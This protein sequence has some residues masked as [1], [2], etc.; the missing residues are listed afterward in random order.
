MAGMHKIIKIFKETKLDGKTVKYDEDPIDIIRQAEEDKCLYRFR[1]DIHFCS[2]K[3]S[4]ENEDSVIMVFSIKLPNTT[5]G[6]SASSE[7]VMDV[8]DLLENLLSPI[9]DYKFFRNM[10]GVN[11]NVAIM[12]I[13]KKISKGIVDM[14]EG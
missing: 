3:T 6:S 7:M 12:Q 8:V 13:I 2:Y 4:Y 9:Q 10:D 1:K 5:T 14:S 11:K